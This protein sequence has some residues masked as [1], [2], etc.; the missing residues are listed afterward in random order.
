[1]TDQPPIDATERKRQRRRFGIFAATLGALLLIA[2]TLLASRDSA[3]G[4]IGI[5]CLA[6]GIGLLVAGATLA[7]GHNPL[8]RRKR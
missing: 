1:M 2:G 4:A 3:L 6:Y 5:G 8:D 7:I